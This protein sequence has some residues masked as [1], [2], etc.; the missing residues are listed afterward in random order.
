[1]GH[2]VLAHD[3]VELHWVINYGGYF[4][5]LSGDDYPTHVELSTLRKNSESS[6]IF[7]LEAKIQA[8]LS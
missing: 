2:S 8:I 5:S 1:M 3:E 6:L 7:G 4:F